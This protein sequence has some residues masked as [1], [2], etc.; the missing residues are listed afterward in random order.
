M[1]FTA[2]AFNYHALK[3]KKWIIYHGNIFS[4]YI[5]GLETIEKNFAVVE[6]YFSSVISSKMGGSG[7]R[8]SELDFE[9]AQFEIDDMFESSFQV[10]TVKGVTKLM[11]NEDFEDSEDN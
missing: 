4:K 7:M 3:V 9:Y 11:H 6:H 5:L 8:G 1:W 10:P 2:Y